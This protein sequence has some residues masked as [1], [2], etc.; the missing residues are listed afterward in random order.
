MSNLLEG[1]RVK[2]EIVR[3]EDVETNA[4]VRVGISDDRVQ[5]LGLLVQAG[6]VL[7]PI[8]VIP[9]YE[10]DAKG[11]LSFVAGSK[12]RGVVDGRHRLRMED[13]LLDHTEVKVQTIVSGVETEAQ[14]IALAFR[15]NNVEG[16]LPPD[17]QDIGHTIEL[18]L[19]KKVPKKD[20]PALLGLPEVAVRKYVNDVETRWE[21]AKTYRGYKIVINQGISV[22]EA[23]KQAGT[24]PEKLRNY[25]AAGRRKGREE[26]VAV[27]KKDISH[28]YKSLS[29]KLQMVMRGLSKKYDDGDVVA[30]D[31]LEILTSIEASQARIVKT[32]KD[33]RARFEAKLNNGK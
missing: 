23:A 1:I 6:T 24:T 33:L 29:T 14:L 31:V 26:D 5:F 15:A 20:I 18:L 13:L 10:V 16:P 32:V 22:P 25:I 27:V 12:K 28:T 11:R 7:E 8:L 9:E 17:Q 21:R 19:E 2:P 4:F 30:Q 3:I